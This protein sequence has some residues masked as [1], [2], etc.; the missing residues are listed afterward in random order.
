MFRPFV[1]WEYDGLLDTERNYIWDWDWADWA[2]RSNQ[3]ISLLSEGEERTEWGLRRG[4]SQRNAICKCITNKNKT[5]HLIFLLMWMLCSSSPSP[6]A[7][8]LASLLAFQ[9]T[10]HP[11]KLIYLDSLLWL[12]HYPTQTNATQRRA[13]RAAAWN[14][15]NFRLRPPAATERLL[16]PQRNT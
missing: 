15:L 10:Q 11:K 6:R 12:Y 8:R 1:Q 16:N 9:C 5:T 3:S 14:M 2:I 4:K 7:S 13:R